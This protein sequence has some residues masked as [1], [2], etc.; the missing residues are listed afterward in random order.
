MAKRSNNKYLEIHKDEIKFFFD[1]LT[2]N[3][4]DNIA[5]VTGSGRDFVRKVLCDYKKY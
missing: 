2:D 3:S 5:N 1:I 4:I